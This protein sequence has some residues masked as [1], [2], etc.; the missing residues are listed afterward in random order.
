MTLQDKIKRDLQAGQ[1][2][3]DAMAMRFGKSKK[4]VD[5]VL[6]R[7]EKDGIVISFPIP[8]GI[9]VWRLKKVVDKNQE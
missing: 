6:E 3:A 9:L 1:S 8:C 2:S 5:L 7:M 4:D